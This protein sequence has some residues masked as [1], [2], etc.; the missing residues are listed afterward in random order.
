MALC[1]EAK[2]GHTDKLRDYTVRRPYRVESQPIRSPVLT[3]IMEAE[4]RPIAVLHEMFPALMG[5]VDDPIDLTRMKYVVVL[6]NREKIVQRV[7]CCQWNQ[8]GLQESRLAR[9]EDPPVEHPDFAW[10]EALPWLVENM[11]PE[12]FKD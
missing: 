12:D 7:R 2:I 3:Q 11:K 5:L 9:I 1:V 6:R 8:L 10:N 4:I